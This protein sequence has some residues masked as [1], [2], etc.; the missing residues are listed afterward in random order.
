MTPEDREFIRAEIAGLRTEITASENRLRTE[1]TE[2]LDRAVEALTAN[3]SDL[4]VE[5]TARLDTIERRTER[6]EITIG[7]IL[8]QLVGINKSM[9]EAERADSATAATLASQQRI[10]TDLVA[11]VSALERKAS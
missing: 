4:R 3:L 2:R 5:M 7:S 6:T 10:I 1:F 8:M 11:R 9:T